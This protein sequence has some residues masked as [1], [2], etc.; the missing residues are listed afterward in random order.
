MNEKI[1]PHELYS[2]VEMG[3]M[4]SKAESS[5]RVFSPPNDNLKL[6]IYDTADEIIGKDYPMQKN[7]NGIFEVTI[8]EDMKGKFYT[9]ITDKGFE[10]TDPYSVASSINSQ[11]TAIIDLKDTNPEGWEEHFRPNIKV[12]EAIIYEMH[13]KDFT[14]SKNSNVKNRGKFLGAVEKGTKYK[15][16]KTSLDHLIE[17]G[18]THVHLLPIYDYISVDEREEVFNSDRNYNWGYDPE[19]YNVPEGSYAT[20][21]ECPINRILELKT[22]IMKFHEAGIKVV[23]DVVYNHVYR[24][25]NSNFETLYPGYY[26]RYWSDGSPSD[27]AGCGTEMDTQRPM[28]RKFILDSIKYWMEEYKIDGFRFDLMGL[29]DVDTM[30]AVVELAKSI[31]EDVLIY[32]E[33]W[34]GGY[35]ALAADK[36]TLKGLQKDKGFACFNDEFRDC[37]KGD[38]NG[39]SL[40]FAMGNFNKKICVETGIAGS[41]DLDS[42]HHGFTHEATESINYAN[43]HDDLILADK[44]NLSMSGVDNN[45]KTAINKLTMSILLTSFGIPF[46]HEGNEFLRTKSGISNTYNGPASINK[47]DWS[48]K[49]KNREVF[50]YVKDLISLR[51]KIGSFSEFNRNDIRKRLFFFDFKTSP[52]IGYGIMQTEVAYVIFHNA[53]RNNMKLNLEIAAQRI[54]KSYAMKNSVNDL[55]I[56]KIFDK[57]GLTNDNQRVN[58][59]DVELDSISTEAYLVKIEK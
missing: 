28:Y 42:L 22:M 40:G 19:L 46:I 58:I 12:S 3:L 10:V 59:W 34:S 7:E 14:F 32:G 51:K 45:K 24:G 57:N 44:I 35:T 6:R 37:L 21:P 15:G 13:I 9:Y 20:K 8:K 1:L 30:E 4:Y 38:N 47:I 55:V 29:I 56:Y 39:T 36:M 43:S 18:V 25:K 27:G 11:K 41:I 16:Q 2:D 33:P 50:D 52:L 31:D 23:V 26:L 54:L 53:S 48:L 49:E 5:F 17:L